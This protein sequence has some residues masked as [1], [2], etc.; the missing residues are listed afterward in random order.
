MTDGS[1]KKTKLNVRV[2][3]AKKEEWKEA[4]EEGETLT[5]LVQRAVD[6]EI[7]DEYVSKDA[8]SDVVGAP[9]QSEVDLSSVTSQLDELQQ[10]VEAFENKLDTLSVATEQED[11]ESIEELAIDILPL[12]PSY[13]TDIPKS[14]RR[15]MAQASTDSPKEAIHSLMETMREIDDFP[16]IDGS[17]QRLARQT[18]EPTPKVREAL[19]Y[20]EHETTENV[21]S[22]LIEGTRHWV[23]DV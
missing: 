7:R 10:T 16:Y 18:R 12:L 3:P 8:I 21:S 23:K 2:P 6:H 11:E 5:S 17:A 9:N 14:H 22:A 20:L 1:H 19:I 4:L 13:K 15:H